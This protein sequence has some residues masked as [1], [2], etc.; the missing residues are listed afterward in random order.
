MVRE[1]QRAMIARP[2]PKAA[3]SNF[4]GQIKH[5]EF[6]I[7]LAH[8]GIAAVVNSQGILLT[9]EFGLGTEGEHIGPISP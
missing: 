1:E 2:P 6:G 7:E 5:R 4:N 8:V 3:P 9:D